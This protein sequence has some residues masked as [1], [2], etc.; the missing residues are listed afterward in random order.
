MQTHC[1]EAVDL[2]AFV[3]VSDRTWLNIP[4]MIN[5]DDE[6][7]LQLSNEFKFP[8]A[9]FHHSHEAY[10]VPEVLKQAYGMNRMYDL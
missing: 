2:E 3:R 8:V 10:L 9:A 5:I 4:S 1:Y 7:I 6:L